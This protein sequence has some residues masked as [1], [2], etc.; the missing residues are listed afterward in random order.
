MADDERPDR[1]VE[2]WLR[3]EP[4]DDVTRRRLVST[5]LRESDQGDTA[6]SRRSS[7]AWRWLTAAA[8]LVV[9][10]VVGL[11]VLTAGGGNDEEQAS[12]N[13]RTEL[14]P[15]AAGPARDVGDYGDLDD[16]ANLASL[17]AALE[18]PTAA[19]GSS[20]PL[21][22]GDAADSQLGSA[23]RAPTGGTGEL[24]LCGITAPDDGSI[25]AQ[26]TGTIDGRRA[27]IVLVEAADG[28][29]SFEAVLEDPCEVRPLP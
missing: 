24:R 13:D 26:G 10:L 6:D 19:S 1:Q 7:H 23:E 9:V 28:T 16:P 27:A 14:T 8:A 15:K 12:R 25:V 18:A 20:E 21:A 4:L 17:R 11:A 29:R 22:T 2:Q 3:V 5:A